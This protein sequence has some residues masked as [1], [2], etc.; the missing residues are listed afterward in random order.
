[1]WDIETTCDGIIHQLINT[2]MLVLTNTQA[3]LKARSLIMLMT[4]VT[5]KTN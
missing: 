2:I 4:S 5:Y 3:T 1:M